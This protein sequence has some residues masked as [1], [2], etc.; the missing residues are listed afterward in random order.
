M[1]YKTLLETIGNTPLIKLQNLSPYPHVTIL[2]KCEFMNPSGSIKDR[3]VAYII[4]DAEKRGLLKPG[5]TIVENTSGNTGAA[6]AMIAAI[7]GYKAVLTMPDKVSHEK[8]DALR[9]Y[10]AEIVIS[11][12]S[13]APDSPEHYVNVAKRLAAE[14][15]NSFR[16]NQYD[17]IK[18]SE[19]HYHSTG[20]EIW[21]QTEGEIDILVAAASTGGT[22]T[23]I[24]RYL[25]EKN[26]KIKTVVPDP[27]GSIY[28]QYFKTG[29]LPTNA[30]CTYQVEGI[31]E[32][33]LVKVIDFS[34]IDEVMQVS[35][36]DA[37]LTAR[38]LAEEEGLLVGGSS[39]AN[40]WAALQIATTLTQPTTIVTLLPDGG[41]K[42]LSKFYNDEWMV[43]QGFL[44]VNDP[45]VQ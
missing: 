32:D 29:K 9:A 4:E 34:V 37:F 36:R 42:Y 2:A 20:P 12:T 28:Y 16:I 7:K 14:I 30:A 23:G 11:P 10:G 13:A 39:G 15:P 1:A 38:R 8:Q 3:I 31:G 43:R 21:Q 6:A 19:A 22:V 41:I 17:N 27:I 18:N 5:G 40:V 33:H 26:P 25:K 35:D 44:K 45:V 24:G